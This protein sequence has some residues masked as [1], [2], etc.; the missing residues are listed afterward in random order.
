MNLIPGSELEIDTDGNEMRL[1]VASAAPRLIRKEGVLV[2]D[3]GGSESNIDIAD[4]INKE[5]NKRSSA[6]VGPWE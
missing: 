3:G 4:F 2:S 6:L 5:R 1:R